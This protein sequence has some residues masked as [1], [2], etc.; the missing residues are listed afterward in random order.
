MVGDLYPRL[1]ESATDHERQIWGARRDAAFSIFYMGIN[2]GAM[3]GPFICSTLGELWNWHLGFSAAGFGMILGLVQYR[4]GGR[5]L[6]E[7]GLFRSDDPGEVIARRQRNFYLAAAVCAATAAWIVF[8]V[9]GGALELV[10]FVTWVGYAILLVVVLFFAYLIFG[11]RQAAGLLVLFA[12]LVAAFRAGVA[13]VPVGDGTAAGQ[14]AI[15][16]TLGVFIVMCGGLLG[17]GRAV[18]VDQ[19]RLMVIFWLF[20][21]AA[22]F[23]SGFEQGG[24]SMN[25]FAQ[26]LTNRVLFGFEVPTGWLQNINPFFIIVLAPVFGTMWTWLAT[27]DRNPSIP[28][29]FA[30]GLVGLAGGMFVLAW[31]AAYASETSRVSMAWL[32]VSYFL[33]TCGE[34]ALSPVGLSSMTKLAPQGRLGQMMGIWFI[35]A[36]LGNLFAGLVAAQLETLPA[37]TLFTNV[38]IFAGA[39]GLLAIVVSPGVKRLMGGVS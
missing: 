1:P 39:A 11:A 25:L 30:L 16:G 34:L 33:F 9:M 8:L 32:T 26:D 35:A 36:A 21:L 10:A 15:V 37:A 31:G 13:G 28:M 22:I 24:S 4:L 27:R 23:W 38:A 14:W 5:H 20:I 29:K 19:K 2:V 17:L 6:G 12:V 3:L 18:S 7:A